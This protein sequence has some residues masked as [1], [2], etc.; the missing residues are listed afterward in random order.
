MIHEYRCD[1]TPLSLSLSLS[2]IHEYCC[3]LTPLSLSIV[4]VGTRSGYK[5]MNS[6]K[7]SQVKYKIKRIR[8]DV[9][10]LKTLHWQSHENLNLKILPPV[11]VTLVRQSL[12]MPGWN[13]SR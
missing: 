5:T 11:T 13:F 12:E 10:H 7:G 4:N 2:P 6:E 8:Q 3:D 9:C 1:L